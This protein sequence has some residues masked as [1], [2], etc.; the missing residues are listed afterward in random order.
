MP[1]LK[2]ASPSLSPLR[3]CF[4]LGRCPLRRSAAARIKRLGQHRRGI[5]GG[6]TGR[7]PGCLNHTAPR[8]E[9]PPIFAEKLVSQRAAADM[10]QGAKANVL[11]HQQKIGATSVNRSHAGEAKCLSP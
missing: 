5:V 11:K 8:R 3:T 7:T 4:G 10:S 2:H 6:E 1:T 9:F